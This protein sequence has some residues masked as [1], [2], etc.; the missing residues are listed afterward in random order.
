MSNL[1]HPVGPE[2]ASV[3]WRRRVVVI[4]GALLVLFLFWS[5]ISPG[6]GSS[7]P[8]ASSS[9]PTALPTVSP[10][11]KSSESPSAAASGALCLEEDIQVTVSADQTTF[12]AGQSASFIMKITNISQGACSRDVGSAANT[13][14]IASGDVDVWSSDACSDPGENQVEEIPPGESFAVKGTW[15]TTINSTGCSASAAA[16]QPGAYQVVATNGEVSSE[17]IVFTLS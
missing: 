9:S 5:I 12:T 2:P 10:G 11:K 13:F 4:V 1:L 15:D 6:G 8:A 17:P 16:A 14:E 7:E 3:Y